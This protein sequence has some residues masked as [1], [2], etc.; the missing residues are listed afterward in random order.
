MR[1]FRTP[2]FL[3]TLLTHDTLDH[4]LYFAKSF[5]QVIEKRHCKAMETALRG[6]G[7]GTSRRWKW[8]FEAIVLQKGYLLNGLH[9]SLYFRSL[10]TNNIRNIPNILFEIYNFRLL[11]LKK[12]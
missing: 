9:K 2:K 12:S 1:I 11:L 4:Q 10:Q 8:H 7:N 3:M 6:N 5:F